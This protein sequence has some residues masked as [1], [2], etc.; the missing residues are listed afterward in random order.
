MNSQLIPAFPTVS[1][2]KNTVEVVLFRNGTERRFVY[3]AHVIHVLR[4]KSA[5][6]L[7]EYPPHGSLDSEGY[8]HYLQLTPVTPMRMSTWIPISPE[9]ARSLEV[10]V[11]RAK[12]VVV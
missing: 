2:D 1:I 12:H 6:I 8:A 7:G 5:T 4:S 9:E 10:A 3:P 11:L